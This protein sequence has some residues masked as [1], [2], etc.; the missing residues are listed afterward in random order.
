MRASLVSRL[1][2]AQGFPARKLWQIARWAR[3]HGYS[4][5]PHEP[6][7]IKPQISIKEEGRE[8]EPQ[9]ELPGD[10]I[11]KSKAS[12]TYSEPS[13][14]LSWLGSHAVDRSKLE[15][16]IVDVEALTETPVTI[17]GTVKK[18]IS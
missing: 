16:D 6:V 3:Q 13:N 18:I 11:N 9:A 2:I 12:S 5:L 4:P 17:T 1:L 7:I 15:D 14:V 8:W 10:N